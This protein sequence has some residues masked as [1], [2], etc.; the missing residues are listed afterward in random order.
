[1]SLRAVCRRHP[2]TSYCLLAFGFSWTYWFWLLGQ[3]LHV[4]PGSTASHLPGLAGP[5]LAGLLVSAASGGR[6]AVM[7]LLRRCLLL[8]RPWGRALLLAL[9][10]LLLGGLLFLA[11]AALGRALPALQDFASY[12]GAPADLSLPAL[13]LLVL[14]LNGVGEEGGWRGFALPALA[15]RHSRLRAALGVAAVWMLWHAPLFVLNRSMAAMLGPALL[16]WALSLAAGAI[17]LAWLYFETESVL[18]VALWHTGFNFMVATLPGR[19]LV[20]AVLSTA[21][22]VLGCGLA[23]RW[24]RAASPPPPPP[25]A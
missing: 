13:A 21:V 17:V 14:L 3:G 19:G 24:A 5:L 6:A 23:L 22:M 10:P 15:R 8:P 16:G 4:E 1:M 11:L 9:S 20:A 7:A 12:P 2:F 18:V 25:R